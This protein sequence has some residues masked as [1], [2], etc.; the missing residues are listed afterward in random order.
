[1]TRRY[2]Q[3]STVYD[4]MRAYSLNRSLTNDQWSMLNYNL[5]DLMGSRSRP[6][7]V[8]SS[9]WVRRNSDGAYSLNTD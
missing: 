3:I 1:M 8:N 2:D 4:L 7:Q 6:Y 5:T 9:H